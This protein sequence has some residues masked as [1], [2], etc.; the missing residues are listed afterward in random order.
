VSNADLSAFLR[1]VA[2]LLRGGYEQS[3]RVR[4][5]LPKSELSR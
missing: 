1:S 4:V 5:N 2:D 3:E